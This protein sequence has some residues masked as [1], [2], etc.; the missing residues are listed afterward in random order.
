[1][2]LWLWLLYCI[3]R[4]YRHEFVILKNGIKIIIENFNGL[5]IGFTNRISD[6]SVMLIFFYF[7]S[8]FQKCG[9]SKKHAGVR[10]SRSGAVVI[11]RL[12]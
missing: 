9:R 11:K 7:S 6:L 2:I 4:S 8:Y 1:M 3:A 5:R 12:W 10:T